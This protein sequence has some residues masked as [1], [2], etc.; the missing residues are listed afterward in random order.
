MFQVLVQTIAFPFIPAIASVI[1]RLPHHQEHHLG[2][3]QASLKR[4]HIIGMPDLDHAGLRIDPEVA[5]HPDRPGGCNVKDLVEQRVAAKAGALE[6]CFES[7]ES[8]KRHIGKIVPT[9]RATIGMV[10][11]V[12]LRGMRRDKRSIQQ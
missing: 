5:C 6:E 7:I 9:H 11:L 2:G 3:R 1:E 8:L 10:G 12:K 4:R